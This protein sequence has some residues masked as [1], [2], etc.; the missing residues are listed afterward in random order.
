MMQVDELKQLF[1]VGFSSGG[2]GS[3]KSNDSNV[4]LVLL[5]GWGITLTVERFVPQDAHKPTVAS[6]QW[7]ILPFRLQRVAPKGTK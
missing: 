2:R 3:N 1:S 6:N 5:R 7:A 4:G